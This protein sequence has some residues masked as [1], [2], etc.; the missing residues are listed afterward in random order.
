MYVYMQIT[1]DIWVGGGV[2]FYGI[3]TPA[4]HPMPNTTYTYIY[5]MYNLKTNSL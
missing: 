1:V 2:C 3:S 4:G 5:D